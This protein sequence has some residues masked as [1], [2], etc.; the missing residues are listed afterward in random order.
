MLAN[1]LLLIGLTAAQAGVITGGGGGSFVCRDANNSVASVDL[2]DLWE[3]R[4]I[5][6]LKLVSDSTNS[7]D[8]RFARAA[9]RLATIDSA[10]AD[11]VRTNYAFIKKN[12]VMGGPRVVI[13]P[14]N[15][16]NDRIYD[17]DCPLEGMMFFDDQRK[18]LV[19]KGEVFSKLGLQTPVAPQTQFAAAYFHESL[20]K[21]MRD[22]KL[23]GGRDS[24]LTRI[25]VGC[26]FAE[27]DLGTCLNLKPVVLPADRKVW[28][29]EIRSGADEPGLSFA[30]Y[31]KNKDDEDW[32]IVPSRLGRATFGFELLGTL[33]KIPVTLP[34]MGDVQP[35]S[36]AFELD[37]GAFR[38]TGLE[39]LGLPWASMRPPYGSADFTV[40]SENPLTIRHGDSDTT[41]RCR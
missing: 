3:A 13:A 24:V 20:Y 18:K 36:G 14:P 5:S 15:D 41:Y 31:K 35:G 29:C 23:E 16:A 38:I 26:L 17:R 40:V 6:G 7:V 12:L 9:D 1:F 4:E 30:V 37:A 8:T 10:L 34:S 27:G 25:I 32:V 21:A 19:V 2:L 33:H 39:S 22:D 28:R 11:E